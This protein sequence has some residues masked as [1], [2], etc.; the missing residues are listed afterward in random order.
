MYHDWVFFSPLE[1]MYVAFNLGG[2]FKSTSVPYRHSLD[3]AS[4]KTN[5]IFGP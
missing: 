3:N 5:S 2:K 1:S 4:T